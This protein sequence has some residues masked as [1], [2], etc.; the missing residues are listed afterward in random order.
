MGKPAAGRPIINR[1]PYLQRLYWV[2]NSMIRRCHD[3][4]VKEYLAYG[5]RGIA[6]CSE[7]RDFWRF[8]DDMSPRPGNA[9]LDR[10]DNDKGYAPDN[11]RWVDYKQ[12]N[13]NRRWCLIVDG[14]TLKE[15]MRRTGQLHRYRMVTKRISKGM[16][17]SDALAQPPR[18][19]NGKEQRA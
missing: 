9:V 10:I 8:H 14:V 3:P 6:V 19:W 4:R 15:Y 12:S 11:C 2:W 5:G 16:S 18:L 7:W 1:D 13:S 17:I